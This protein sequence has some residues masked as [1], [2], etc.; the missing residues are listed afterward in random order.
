[1]IFIITL[2]PL[3]LLALS[4]NIALTHTLASFFTI[5][6]SFLGFYLLKGKAGLLIAA[7]VMTVF[8]TQKDQS[9]LIYDLLSLATAIAGGFLLSALLKKKTKY[10]FLG[11]LCGVDILVVSLSLTSAALFPGTLS[12]SFPSAALPPVFSGVIFSGYFLGGIDL[13]CAIL[14]GRAIRD[15]GLAFKPAL[16]AYAL[17]QTL[18]GVLIAT[19]T[20][21]ALPAVLAPSFGLAVGYLA[22][23]RAKKRHIEF[24]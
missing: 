8:L 20:T 1:M 3:S 21:S 23:R 19:S 10:L 7:V 14:V 16:I 15:E 24:S 5:I 4:K 18:L 9:G 13:S 12:S 6:A 22:S 17:A 2:I 11:L